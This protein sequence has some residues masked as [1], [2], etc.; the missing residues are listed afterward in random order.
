MW[1]HR[2]EA[3]SETGKA[4][5]AGFIIGWDHSSLG[6]RALCITG[7]LQSMDQ[8]HSSPQSS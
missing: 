6:W 3:G 4:A 7:R 5:A 1:L 8:A 2:E